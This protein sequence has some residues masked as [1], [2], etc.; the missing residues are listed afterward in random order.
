VTAITLTRR[1]AVGAGLGLGATLTATG[2]MM[3]MAAAPRPAARPIDMLL[4]DDG[5]VLPPRLA[6]FVAAR[7]RTLAVGAI[8]LDAP[9]YAD[10][11]R[12]LND[13]DCVLGLSSGA[14]LF[15][16][17]RIAWDHGFRLIGRSQR[18]LTELADTACAQDTLAFLQGAQPFVAQPLRPAGAYRP[19]H[20][21]A[22]I[23]VWAMRKASAQRKSW[24]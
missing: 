19:S 18:C 14:T 13:G 20:D 16:V 22:T 1:A 24:S 21:D 15:C 12:R 9:G 10:L 5:L 11:S 4:V 23:H 3:A 17:E 8:R 6:A 2:G 7:R